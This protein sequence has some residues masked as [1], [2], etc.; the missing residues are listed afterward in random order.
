M[1]ERCLPLLSMGFFQQLAEVERGGNCLAIPP[2]KLLHTLP[3]D[4]AKL[5]F[6]RI[7]ERIE[8]I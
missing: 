3:S 4:S 6:G 7:E 8:E 2:Q 1:G 5:G